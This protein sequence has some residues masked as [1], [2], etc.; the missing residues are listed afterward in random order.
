VPGHGDGDLRKVD[1]FVEKP[2]ASSAR[3][4]V[5]AGAVWNA[6][7]VAG[8]ARAILHLYSRRFHKIVLAMRAVV[9]QSRITSGSSRAAI[10]LYRELPQIDF[11]RD[12]LEGAESAL[13]LLQVPRCG[14]SDLGTPKR[15]ADTLQTLPPPPT[16]DGLCRLHDL[17]HAVL[18]RVFRRAVGR[19]LQPL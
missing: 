19:A 17:P 3:A 2:D 15:L 6:F 5:E 4:L 13:R 10:D 16:R 7:I 8:R 12:I 14:W 18:A 1:R 9:A 11:S